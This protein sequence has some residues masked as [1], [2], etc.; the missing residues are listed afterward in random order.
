MTEDKNKK[1]IS[2]PL[3]HM[4]D[5]RIEV[6]AELFGNF[7]KAMTELVLSKYDSLFPIFSLEASPIPDATAKPLDDDGNWP[8]TGG[9]PVHL[10]KYKTRLE[11]IKEDQE[12][13]E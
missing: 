8:I 6:D 7:A 1:V 5:E 10:S 11:F 13:D 2:L 4:R 9:V 12:D 3:D